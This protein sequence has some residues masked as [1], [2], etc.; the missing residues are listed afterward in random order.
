MLECHKDNLKWKY[1]KFYKNYCPTTVQIMYHTKH[2]W[3]KG[4]GHFITEQHNGRGVSDS[5][6]NSLAYAG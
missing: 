5:T 1:F 6:V 4:L 3:V 2:S